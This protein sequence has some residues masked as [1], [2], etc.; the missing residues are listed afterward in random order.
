MSNKFILKL[1]KLQ[2]KDVT[3]TGNIFDPQDP[4]LEITVAGK[5]Y[6]TKRMKD[7]KTNAL[8]DESFQ[9]EV[10]ETDFMNNCLIM[11]DVWNVGVAKKKH[12]GKAKAILREKITAFNEENNITFD[13]IHISS[14]ENEIH[15]GKVIMI[16]KLMGKPLHSSNK[17]FISEKVIRKTSNQVNNSNVRKFFE[18]GHIICTKIICKDLLNVEVFGGKNDPYV[19]LSIGNTQRQTNVLEDAGANCSYDHLDFTF[20]IHKRAMIAEYL[21]VEVWDKNNI[22]NHRIIGKAEKTIA[23][24]FMDEIIDNIIDEEQMISLEL[25][26]EKKKHVGMV[27][28]F[29]TLK[30]E[31]TTTTTDYYDL[32]EDFEDDNNQQLIMNTSNSMKSLAT[33]GSSSKGMNIISNNDN[34]R[35]KEVN[36]FIGEI[37]ASDIKPVE[38]LSRYGDSNDLYLIASYKEDGKEIWKHTT[39]VQNDSGS[40]AMWT[41][42]RQTDPYMFLKS[43]SGI[44]HCGVFHI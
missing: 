21:Q 14:G 8:F 17:A 35:Y 10:S 15:Q 28:L 27:T 16:A 23:S 24:I 26:N 12:V 38:L 22:I 30:H 20:D 32:D 11:I 34:D 19:I 9:Y 31:E 37:H 18:K 5:S 2:I 43:K 7:V 44:I 41:F 3:D 39:N 25:L 40:N 33:T 13:L 36:L 6:I 29:L 4:V 42:N 1:T